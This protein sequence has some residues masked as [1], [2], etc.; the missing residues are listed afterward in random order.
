MKNPQ[1]VHLVGSMNLPSAEM[2]M[3]MAASQLGDA[4]Q[5]LPD[6]EPGPRRGWVFYQRPMFTHHQRDPDGEMLSRFAGPGQDI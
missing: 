5:R 2:A 3:T 4:L 1:H 6:G